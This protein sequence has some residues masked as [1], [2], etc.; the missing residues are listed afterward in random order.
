[1]GPGRAGPMRS[2][3]AAPDC[4]GGLGN[5][6]FRKVP[7]APAAGP[8]GGVARAAGSAAGGATAYARGRCRRY[9]ATGAGRG[10]GYVCVSASARVRTRNRAWE[11][12]H[13]C[14]YGIARLR[15]GGAPS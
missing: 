2:S 3:V 1:M 10:R 8:G 15:G 14:T 4:C 13:V 12:V 11:C 5:L 6:D 7:T 9:Q